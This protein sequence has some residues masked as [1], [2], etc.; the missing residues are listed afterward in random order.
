MSITQFNF[1]ELFEIEISELQL[2]FQ[3]RYDYHLQPVKM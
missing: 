3:A 2:C 1:E